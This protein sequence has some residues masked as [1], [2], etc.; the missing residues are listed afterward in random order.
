MRLG[1]ESPLLQVVSWCEVSALWY[2]AR[3][4]HPHTGEHSVVASPGSV[5]GMFILITVFYMV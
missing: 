4:L 2:T 3:S 5:V 1:G